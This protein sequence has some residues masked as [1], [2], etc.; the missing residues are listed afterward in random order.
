MSNE[1]TGWLK[2]LAEIV[3]DR[4]LTV[5]LSLTVIFWVGALCLVAYWHALGSFYAAVQRAVGPLLAAISV[6]ALALLFTVAVE[7]IVTVLA[8]PVVDARARSRSARAEQDRQKQDKEKKDAERVQLKQAIQHFSEA[9]KLFVRCFI[10][11]GRR[12]LQG[13]EI[14]SMYKASSQERDEEIRSKQYVAAL[15]ATRDQGYLEGALPGHDK[16]DSNYW[17]TQG[18]YDMLMEEPSLIGSK[19]K[20]RSIHRNKKAT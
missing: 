15:D 19:Q 18:L 6:F 7:S 17:L 9:Q 12:R 4:T 14:W 20:A 2:S 5:R 10:D 11:L 3:R 8:T 1:E 16:V 13:R